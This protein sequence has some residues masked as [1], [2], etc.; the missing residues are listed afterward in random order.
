MKRVKEVKSVG[1]RAAR[2]IAKM[3]EG[4]ELRSS[5]NPATELEITCDYSREYYFLLSSF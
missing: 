2:F 4:C 1:G 3:W 5:H